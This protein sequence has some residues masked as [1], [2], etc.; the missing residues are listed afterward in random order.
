MTLSF[1]LLQ[2]ILY[3]ALTVLIF[4]YV[5]HQCF[6]A[7]WTVVPELKANETYDD[8]LFFKNISDFEHALSPSL[9]V[10]RDTERSHIA[11]SGNLDIL[12]YQDYSD[13]NRENQRYKLRSSYDISNRLKLRLNGRL[14]RDYTFEYEFEESG[15][16]AEQNKRYVYAVKPGL[17]YAIN[18]TNNM[19]IDFSYKE[20]DNQSG[21]AVDYISNGGSIF[22]S[23]LLLDQKTSLLAGMSIE[24]T[25]F[26]LQSGDGQQTVYGSAL[27]IS[28]DMGPTFN[29]LFKIG[30]TWTESEF[31]KT[32]GREDGDDIGLSVNA[33]LFW[34][35]AKQTDISW[36]FDHGQYQSIYAENITR[37][38]VRANIGHD[39]TLKWR[40][41][42]GGSYY[43]T[44]TEGYVSDEEKDTWQIGIL[45][46]YSLRPNMS[47]SLGYRYRR[48]DEKEN[49]TRD[50]NRVF[51]QFIVNF[52]KKMG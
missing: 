8:N 42:A 12:R 15:I 44:Q 37:S 48:I 7:D 5:P 40:G 29:I 9:E 27:G 2:I 16:I 52:P 14:Q 31:D 45:S 1:H 49:D 41:E 33:H 38:R 24:Q 50:G 28:R 46:S 3:V 30:P 39:F 23:K 51:I 6:A 17:N 43:N 32:T 19:Y 20:A 47:V 21:Y 22:W 36:K 4:C 13:Y 35:A 10:T 18:E 34:Q 26:D 11:L 25:D